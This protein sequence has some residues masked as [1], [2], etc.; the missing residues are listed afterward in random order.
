[1][2]AQLAATRQ[3]PIAAVRARLIAWLGDLLVL[4]LL[5]RERGNARAINGM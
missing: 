1:M 5:R 3:E 2:V 4:R